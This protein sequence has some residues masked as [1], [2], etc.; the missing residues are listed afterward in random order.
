[1]MG[2]TT[3][4]DLFHEAS[5]K[6]ADNNCV[7]YINEN[8]QSKI[9]YAK[10]ECTVKDFCNWWKSINEETNCFIGIIS[11]ELSIEVIVI[12]IGLVLLMKKVVNGYQQIKYIKYFY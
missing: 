7:T 6:F 1:M 10:M 12:L 4:H 11:E 5:V 3:L 2:G 8:C 9:S